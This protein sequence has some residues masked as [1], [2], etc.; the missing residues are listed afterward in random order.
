MKVLEP[1][2]QMLTDTTFNRKTLSGDNKDSF[3]KFKQLGE[4]TAG[5]V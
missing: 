1:I 2:C 3:V 5:M 4:R